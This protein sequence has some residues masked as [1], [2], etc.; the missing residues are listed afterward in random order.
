MEQAWGFAAQR[1]IGKKLEE[2]LYGLVARLSVLGF[3]LLA[4]TPTKQL[5]RS[6]DVACA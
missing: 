3:Q 5:R 1:G 2:L 4:L 6:I